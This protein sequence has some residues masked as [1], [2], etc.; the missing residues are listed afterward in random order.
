MKRNILIILAFIIIGIQLVPYG[1]DHDNPPVVREPN[2]DSPKT[3]ALFFRA[4]ADCHSNQTQ[5]PWYSHIAPVSW[6][7]QYDV[8]EGRE[9]FNVSMWGVQKRNE[10]DEAAE[11]LTEGEMPL[12]FYVILHPKARLSEGEKNE[13]IKGLKATFGGEETSSKAYEDD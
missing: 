8:N 12:W 7:V 6:L 11:E 9:H 2:W 4:C 5:W 1:R 13:L 10:G 3:R